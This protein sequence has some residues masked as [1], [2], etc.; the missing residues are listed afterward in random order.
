MNI[1]LIEPDNITNDCVTVFGRQY[2]HLVNVHRVK[3]GDTI[4]VGAV[5]GHLGSGLITDIHKDRITL[6]LHLCEPPPKPLPLTLFLALPRPKMLRRILQTA[7][8]MGVKNLHIINA[9]RVEKSFWQTSLLNPEV[10]ANELR[11]G[12]E[13]A[14]DTVIPTVFFHRLFKRFLED[15]IHAYTQDHAAYVAHP[16]A[17]ER[18]PVGVEGP[19]ALAIGPE[20]GF[21]PYEVEK[22]QRVGFASVH[23]GPRILR[24]ENAVP[25]L[26]SRLYPS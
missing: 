14:G 4:R 8:A 23:L 10:I 5:N 16:K 19:C 21:I 12:L 25:A 11:L 6:S 18:C 24:V 22:F 26:V 15:T 1:L 9:H 17:D 2:L 13:Q 20:G 3:P 7:A